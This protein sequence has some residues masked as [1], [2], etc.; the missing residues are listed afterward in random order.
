MIIVDAFSHL[1]ECRVLDQNVSEIALLEA[2]NNNQ[3]SAAVVAPFPA[4]ANP[5]KIHD[6]IAALGTQYPGR[7][8]GLANVNPHINR[9]LYHKEVERAVR[10]LGFVGIVMSTLGHA[11][12]PN[13]DD[14]KTVF[15]AARDLSVPLVIETGS[16]P[17]GLPSALFRRVRDY[18]DVK[19]VVGHSGA[20]MFNSEAEQLAREFPNVYL[21]TSGVPGPELKRLVEGLGPNRVLM[22]SDVPENLSSELAKYRS[23]GLYHY[24]LYQTLGQTAIDLFALKGVTELPEPTPATS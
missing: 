18:S 20:S 23:L 16:V 14:A 8:F 19:I 21:E 3:V 1:G 5:A 17:F 10:Q 11:V 13:G 24:Q 7:I 12:N 22:G 6:Q 15:E 4:P 9:D 2:M